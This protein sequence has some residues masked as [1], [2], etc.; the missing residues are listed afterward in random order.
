MKQS[1][2]RRALTRYKRG[3]AAYERACRNL[4]AAIGLGERL[5]ARQ[6]LIG[7]ALDCLLPVIGDCIAELP[8]LAIALEESQNGDETGAAMKGAEGDE[9]ETD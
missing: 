9:D 6:Q 8:G 3:V 4:A 5:S 7:E 2:I 1:D